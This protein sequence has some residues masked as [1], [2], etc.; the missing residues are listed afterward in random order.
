MITVCD[1]AAG[2]ICPVWLCQ[3]PTAHWGLPDP[4]VVEGDAALKAKAFRAAAVALRRRIELMLALPLATLGRL[5]LRG[6]MD[7]IGRTPA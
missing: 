4:V 2:E 5:S 7:R 1:N 6:E 3:P